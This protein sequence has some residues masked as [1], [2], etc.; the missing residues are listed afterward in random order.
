MAKKILKYGVD[1]EIIVKYTSLT[2]EEIEK[3]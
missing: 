2:K 1:I 3:L